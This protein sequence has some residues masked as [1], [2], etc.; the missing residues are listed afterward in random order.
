MVRNFI[1]DA[2]A[3]NQVRKLF[4]HKPAARMLLFVLVSTL[5]LTQEAF[6]LFALE[7]NRTDSIAFIYTYLLP[8]VHVLPWLAGVQCLRKTKQA[9]H[10]DLINPD[11][12]GLCYSVIIAL[13]ATVY[14]A[15]GTFEL[16]LGFV[17]RLRARP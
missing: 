16:A 7:S 3:R 1:N 11:A 8:L 4:G 13:L 15:L 12:A 10:D 6:L 2:P 9:A 17:L 5:M 14:V